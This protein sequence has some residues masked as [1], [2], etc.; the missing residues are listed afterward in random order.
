V[1]ARVINH[2]APIEFDRA[3]LD[4]PV[5]LTERGGIATVGNLIAERAPQSIRA[6]FGKAA[7]N[8]AAHVRPVNSLPHK[9]LQRLAIEIVRRSD[10]THRVAAIG[11]GDYSRDELVEQIDQNT[12]VGSRIIDAIRLRSAFVEAAVTAG[13][14]R[15]KN[16]NYAN[17]KF[18]AFDF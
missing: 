5:S 12:A 14:I 8:C 3:E 17:V 11:L 16:V 7:P 4:Q 18:P 2:M 15:P 13:K 1:L 6:L 9:A 10:P